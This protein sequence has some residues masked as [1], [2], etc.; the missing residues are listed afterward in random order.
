MEESQYIFD[1]GHTEH[2]I[3]ITIVTVLSIVLITYL[4]RLLLSFKDKGSKRYNYMTYISLCILFISMTIHGTYS[5]DNFLKD[6]KNNLSVTVGT[7]IKEEIGDG[8]DEVKYSYEV[9]GKYYTSSCGRTYNGERIY[10]I[11]VPQGK[12]K[13]LYNKLDP[14]KSIMDFKAPR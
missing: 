7:T 10:D 8:F 14:S 3:G 12:Y 11:N 6:L 5:D 13:V 4:I 1:S 9:N 2:Y